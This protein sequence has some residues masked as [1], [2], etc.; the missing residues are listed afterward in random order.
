M[1]GCVCIGFID[2]MFARK[3]L[4]DYTSLLSPD[5][6]KNNDHMILSYLENE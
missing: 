1:C 2:F 6:F 4:S 3:K 5:D